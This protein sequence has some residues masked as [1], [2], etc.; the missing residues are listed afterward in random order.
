MI[1]ANTPD[2]VHWYGGLTEGRAEGAFLIFMKA[3]EQP[4]TLEEFINK[5][6]HF[7]ESSTNTDDLYRKWQKVH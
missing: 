4:P 1:K 5:F 2:I 3:K 6:K 7:C